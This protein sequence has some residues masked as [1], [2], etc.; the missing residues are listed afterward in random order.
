[1][2]HFCRIRQYLLDIPPTF[3]QIIDRVIMLI[4]V[5]FLYEMITSDN[6]FIT[7]ASHSRN[8]NT[9]TGRGKVMPVFFLAQ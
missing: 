3:E 6:V 7:G 5:K 9:V 2:L 8:T 4:Y 1:M